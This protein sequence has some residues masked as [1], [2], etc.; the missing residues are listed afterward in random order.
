MMMT[1]TTHGPWYI[2]VIP[3]TF[4][5]DLHTL[6]RILVSLTSKKSTRVLE[7]SSVQWW[8]LQIIVILGRMGGPSN[9]GE[10]PDGDRPPGG[11]GPSGAR[12]SPH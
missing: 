5:W 3:V 12:D 10:P 4:M 8:I 6:A 9:G 1:L 11:G 7:G 2:Q